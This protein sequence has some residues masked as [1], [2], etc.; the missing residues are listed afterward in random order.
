MNTVSIVMGV[1][2]AATLAA[3]GPRLTCEQPLFDFGAL[4][5]TQTVHH[6]FLLRN[7]GDETAT[8]SRVATACC[9][10]MA[11]RTTALI[12]PGQSQTFDVSI[13]INGQYG[14]Q[15]N[16]TVVT[17]TPPSGTQPLSLTIIGTATA[18]VEV[19]PAFVSFGDIGPTGSFQR[20]V[21][22]VS[23]D[24][25][26]MVNVTGASCSDA[27][28]AVTVKPLTPH[29]EYAVTVS[30]AEPR[31][32]AVVAAILAISTDHP[33]YGTINVPLYMRVQAEP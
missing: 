7:D 19:D 17:C 11:D 4:D 25:N 26:R 10:K 20:T 24:T 23:H 9:C 15:S 22:V 5:N 3:A 29:H 13:N 30:A 12:P 27:R 2:V 14:F 18:D 8:V 1:V 21:R 28:F 31:A 6:A 33:N 16:S 32:Q